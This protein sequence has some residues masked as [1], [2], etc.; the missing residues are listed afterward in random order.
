MPPELTVINSQS[1]LNLRVSPLP[2]RESAVLNAVSVIPYEFPRL[3]AH[4]PIFFIK[5][6]ES[7][8]FEPVAMLGF[9]QGENL[10]FSNERWDVDYV[11]LQVLR[12]PFSLVRRPAADGVPAALDLAIDMKSVQVRD[13]GG[14]RLFSEDGKAT[15]FL[16][17]RAS[18]MQALVTGSTEAFN[19]TGRLAEL[20]LLESV[21]VKV[22]FVD[23]S[24]KQLQGLYWIA[25][26][27]VQKLTA[28][29]L[30][31]LR[32]RKYLEWMYFQMAS[33]AHVAG[34]VARKNRLISGVAR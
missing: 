16:E 30:V 18:M 23:R 33:L 12:H 17:E 2:T 4:Y 25:G 7:G 22:E 21:Q 11:P 8:R 5:S 34:L 31:D 32:N 26:A 9:D 29:Q 1:H 15:K 14:E 19:F 13:D 6:Q 24:E 27:A 3:L 20:E 10:F 28:D